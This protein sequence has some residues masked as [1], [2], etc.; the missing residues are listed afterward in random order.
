MSGTLCVGWYF[1]MI[2]QRKKQDIPLIKSITAAGI[3]GA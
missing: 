3:T 2:R 1:E